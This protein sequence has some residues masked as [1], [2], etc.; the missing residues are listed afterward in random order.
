MTNYNQVFKQEQ[1]QAV[2]DRAAKYY[3][4]RDKGV[5]IPLVQAP[6]PDALEY[7]YVEFLESTSTYASLD[8][9]ENRDFMDTIH[10]YTDIQLYSQ[11][12]HIKVGA[13]DVRNFGAQLIADKN[14]A[15]LRKWTV[16]IDDG[17]FHGP[18]NEA[19][20]QLAEGIIGQLTSLE[21]LNGTDSNLA[22][23]GYIWKAIIK[24]MNQIPFAMR[25]EGPDMILFMTSNLYKK[26]T[27][28]DRI[29]LEVLEYDMIKKY[30]MNDAEHGFKISKIIITDK[31][32][33][34]ASDDTDGDNAD[35]ADTQGTHD[36]MLLIVPDTRW[37]GR[38]TSAS[39]KKVG[40]GRS[41][42]GDVRLHYS[43]RYRAAVFNT[44]AAV[45]T[46]ALVWA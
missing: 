12:C 23:K 4:E 3:Q 28:P 34:E 43:H 13:N 35:T 14:D 41:D 22:T 37:I 26:L 30:L 32:L 8:Y 27:S 40:E 36:R 10:S 46:E 15:Q 44:N 20:I 39:F 17:N 9:D 45:Y 16:D 7:R 31:I 38:I 19:G 1:Y 33:A 25:E 6:I 21:N 42:L 5:N 18:K 11:N 29:Y 24:M 2:S